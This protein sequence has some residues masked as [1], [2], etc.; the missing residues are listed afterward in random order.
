MNL[1]Y[2]SNI[3][4]LV[5]FIWSFTYRLPQRRISCT[6]EYRPSPLDIPALVSMDEKNLDQ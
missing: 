4:D 3:F 6:I 2:G 1:V 5:L